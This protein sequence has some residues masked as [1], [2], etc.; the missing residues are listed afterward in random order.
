MNK[1]TCAFI[2]TGGHGV[3]LRPY[4][5]DTPK[6]LLRFNDG[7]R[8]LDYTLGLIYESGIKNVFMNYCYGENLFKEVV[9]DYKGKLKIKLIHEEVPIGHGA[10]L[11]MAKKYLLDYEYVISFN[12]DTIIDFD[13][14][15]FI[16]KKSQK[17]ISLLSGH[18]IETLPKTLVLGDGNELLGI[19]GPAGGYFYETRGR[20]KMTYSNYVG[21]NILPS[22]LISELHY[23]EG[24]FLGIFG[25]QDLIELALAKGYKAKAINS[26]KI[27]KFF[28]INTIEEFKEIEGLLNSNG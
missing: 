4:T 20:A 22:T 3:R 27:K 19:E 11:L 6:P 16:N 5:I 24:E 12:G 10:T 17:T 7:K 2:F 8:I 9:S 14:L 28:S 21:V 13:V 25:N 26:I 15:G 23:N 18:S 1:T